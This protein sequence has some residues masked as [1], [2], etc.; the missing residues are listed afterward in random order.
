MSS[1]AVS[2]CNKCFCV[3]YMLLVTAQLAA[4]PGKPFSQQVALN[5]PVSYIDIADRSSC[6]RNYNQPDLRDN[7]AKVSRFAD[8]YETE[9]T[10]Q[11]AGCWDNTAIG[12]IWRLGIASPGAYSLYISFNSLELAAGA[13]LYVYDE[14]GDDICGPF[15]ADVLPHTGA[16]SVPPVKGD[17]IIIELNVPGNVKEYGKV[18]VSKLYHDKLNYFGRYNGLRRLPPSACEENINCENGAFWQTEKRAVCK[19]IT[20]GALCT[21]TLVA[22]T[23]RSRE[24]YLLTAYH[25]IFDQQHAA[26][27]VFFFNYEYADCE[28]AVVNDYQRISGASLLATA[29]GLDYALLKLHQVP[30]ESCHPYY[31]GWDAG[32]R[33]PELPV[34]AIHHPGGLP[35]QL[36]MSYR[37][38]S[39][40]T[41]APLYQQDAFWGV[42][43]EVGMTAPGSSGSP[44]FNKQHRLVGTLTG[45]NATCGGQGTDYFN[46]LSASWKTPSAAGND[47]MTWLDPVH[48][49]ATE[50]DGYD[51][52]GLDSSDCS[53]IWNIGPGEK[54][55]SSP[56]FLPG[57]AAPGDRFTGV[58]EKFLLE[59]SLSLPSVYL[60]VSGISVTASDYINV[61]IWIGDNSPSGLIYRQKVFLN[62]LTQGI[63]QII[64]DSVLKIQGNFFAGYE[65][66]LNAGS[67]FT[68]Y[69]AASRGKDGASG[70]FVYDYTWHAVNSLQ[71][72]YTTSL[73]IG[74]TECYGRT[75]RPASGALLV[76]PNPCRD[77]FYFELPDE[78]IPDEV[79]CFDMAGRALNIEY[80]PG[81]RNIV[82]FNLAKGVYILHV[83]SGD[84]RFQARVLV[85]K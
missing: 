43:W 76:Y 14:K 4:H 53:L 55:E 71:Y 51:P 8:L 66:G 20:D 3:L 23:A 5:T 2:S 1:L 25:I 85:G 42:N 48:N 84:R 72:S 24:P 59:G 70:M 74:I 77:Y 13:S 61:C 16:F 79:K 46:K 32:V 65:T 75:A 39:S 29:P 7:A 49:G 31:A 45:G 40:A 73:A 60:N 80:T 35:K 18:V 15:T 26:E 9:L 12:K 36:A 10:P 22:N 63:N 67:S 54:L 27:A 68:L 81:V 82:H 19:I 37:Y 6:K 52:Y 56:S 83:R 69:R 50:M 33:L 58:A 30:P 57:A 21:G 44:L 17:K 47:L 38:V 41:Y 64:F 34:A 11:N 78:L 28:G 62:Q